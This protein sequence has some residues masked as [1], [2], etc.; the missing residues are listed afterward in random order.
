MTASNAQA[1]AMAL[2][3]CARRAKKITKTEESYMSWLQSH[4]M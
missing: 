2:G 1:Y 3:M 4:L